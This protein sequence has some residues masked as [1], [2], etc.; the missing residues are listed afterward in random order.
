[1]RDLCIACGACV[2]EGRMVCPI[3]EANARDRPSAEAGEIRLQT[4]REVGEI[5][6]KKGAE[7]WRKKK[8]R[9]R[10]SSLCF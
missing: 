8:R 9:E 2:P 7:I 5:H 1:M 3:C 10:H 4:N 6:F